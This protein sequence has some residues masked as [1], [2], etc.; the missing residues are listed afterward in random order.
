[1]TVHSYLNQPFHAEI[2]LIDVG[3][4]PSSAIKVSVASVEDFERA[5]LER[6]YILD[7]LIFQL[8]KKRRKTYLVVRSIEPI[9]EP[10]LD[11]LVDLAWPNGQVY[12]AYTVLLDP[13]A[14]QLDLKRKEIRAQKKKRAY[15]TANTRAP[16]VVEKEVITQMFETSDS[17][18]QSKAKTYGPTLE[19]ET[20]WQIAQRLKPSGITLHQMILAITGENPDAFTD[21]NI[22]G[23]KKGMKLNIPSAEIADTIPEELAKR[24]VFQH[25]LAWE[26]KEPINH[27]LAPPYFKVD[28]EIQKPV[29]TQ[30]KEYKSILPPLPDFT[31]SVPGKTT[32][33]SPFIPSDPS[34]LSAGEDATPKPASVKTQ[35]QDTSSDQ[36]HLRAE[37][38]IAAAA[39]DSVRETN[40]LLTEQ[41]K[42]LQAENKRLQNELQKREQALQ[43]LQE[44]VRKLTL[45][46]G[47]AGQASA[48][49]E[50][51]NPSSWPWVV[52]I[53]VFIIGGALFSYWWFW[54]IKGHQEPKEVKKMEESSSESLTLPIITEEESSENHSEEAE[55]SEPL[56][57]LPTSGV[58]IKESRV[59]KTQ[60]EKEQ[61]TLTKE[62][63][64]TPKEALGDIE[65]QTENAPKILGEPI[66]LEPPEEKVDELRHDAVE[67]MPKP[68]PESEPEPEPKPKPEPESEPESESESEVSKDVS[69]ERSESREAS[70][71]DGVDTGLIEF[72]PYIPEEKVESEPTTPSNVSHKLNEEDNALEFVPPVFEEDEKSKETEEEDLQEDESPPVDEP[73]PPIELSIHHEEEKNSDESIVA[74]VDEEEL[75]PIKSTRALQTLLDLASTYVSMSDYEAAKQSLEEVI[76]YGTEEQKKKAKSMLEQLLDKE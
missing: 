16:G 73:E 51:K 15:S 10:Y 29:S 8:E 54:I 28:R 52:L 12:R 17:I 9:T 76:E 7:A 71:D 58:V 39:I 3:N 36:A 34:F 33:F 45:R 23:L 59:P 75:K 4:L 35:V 41:V 62:P 63:E 67:E 42:L 14:Y 30:K 26:K 40:S 11:L 13:P 55:T 70:E 61:A 74:T 66:V 69:L 64:I 38:A 56:K 68:G 37:M 25:D 27:V 44:Q 20:I 18:G 5:G 32:F 50:Y 31:A 6:S 24:E 2:E 60:E 57:P 22:N 47:L 21:G 49:E 46:Q 19:N 48:T 53:I 1:M 43:N 65:P 72:E